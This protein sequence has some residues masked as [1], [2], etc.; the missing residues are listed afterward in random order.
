MKVKSQEQLEAPATVPDFEA[1]F[2]AD[3]QARRER[4]AKW[5][6]LINEEV[7]LHTG[8]APASRRPSHKCRG[9]ARRMRPSPR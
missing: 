5:I 3:M 6:Q 8:P 9:L 1:L 2:M 7:R 4:L